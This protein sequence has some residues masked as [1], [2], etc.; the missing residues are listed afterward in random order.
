[1]ARKAGVPEDRLFGD[2]R[3]IISGSGRGEGSIEVEPTNGE[4][5]PEAFQSEVKA[6]RVGEVEWAELDERPQGDIMLN[7][8]ER[9]ETLDSWRGGSRNQDGA[10]DLEAHL[11]ALSEVELDRVTRGGG[12]ARS[13]LRADIALDVEAGDVVDDPGTPTGIP[14]DEWDQR[15]GDY[16][17]GW[18]TVHLRRF[19]GMDRDWVVA[20]HA[21]HHRRIER[22][23]H[24]LERLRTGLLPE[25]RQLDGEDLDLTEL[26]DEHATRRAGRAGDGR[27]YVRPARP[28][29]D[30]C[31]RRRYLRAP[32]SRRRSQNRNGTGPYHRGHSRAPRHW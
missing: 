24:R 8:F 16:R 22:L 1:M 12:P 26:V 27:V 11:E 30:S 3:A 7:P 18:C 14:Y 23:A 20:A 19:D 10:D 15:M 29:R 28:R 2:A 13:L 31:C 5:T 6:P 32:R 25:P 21:S 9:V 4:R 17:R